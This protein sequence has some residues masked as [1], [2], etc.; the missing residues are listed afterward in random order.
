MR[1]TSGISLMLL[2]F[3]SLCLM[4]FS[5]L[6]LSGATAD[7]RLSRKSA[8]RTT[9]YYA[10][11]TAANELVA[12]IDAQLAGCLKEAAAAETPADAWA[13]LCAGLPEL[14]PE[15]TWTE[16]PEPALSFSVPVSDGQLLAVTLAVPYPDAADDTLY[17]VVTW[18]IV[19][20]QEWTP[21]SLQNL[22]RTEP[23]SE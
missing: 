19:N 17:D 1:K 20:T 8:D 22:Y 23:E 9:E 21:G 7:E 5:L 6:S 11:E 4:I 2:I 3:L 15:L 18:Q 16:A 12:K 13:G 14:M 10:A